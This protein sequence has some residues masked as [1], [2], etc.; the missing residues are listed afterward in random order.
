MA[1][2]PSAFPPIQPGDVATEGIGNENWHRALSLIKYCIRDKQPGRGITRNK[3]HLYP[4][5]LQNR[6]IILQN[7][8]FQQIL[9]IQL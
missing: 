5:T 8:I 1:S 3:K 9:L 4:G 6:V 7:K 2:M